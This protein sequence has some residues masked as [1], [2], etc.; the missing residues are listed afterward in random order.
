MSP[1]GAPRGVPWFVDLT[2]QAAAWNV[3]D[4]PT[5]PQLYPANAI[6]FPPIL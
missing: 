2:F 5:H 3:F 4:R 1:T 6:V